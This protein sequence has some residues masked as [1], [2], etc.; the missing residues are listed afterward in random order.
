MTSCSD[1]AADPNGT[2]VYLALGAN[3]GDR[4]RTLRCAVERLCCFLD[5]PKCSSVY[6]TAPMYVLDQPLFLNLVMTGLTRKSAIELLRIAN[7]IEHDLGRD[8]R[9]ER[10][11][12]PRPLDIDMLLYGRNVCSDTTLTLPHPRIGER[13][14]VLVPLL[15]LDSE[16]RDPVTTTRYAD[17]PVDR[18]GIFKTDT[19]VP[20]VK[21]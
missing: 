8:R 18:S 10:R 5:D 13:A 7:E 4:S 11:N 16:L 1:T 19:V 2:V 17:I 9:S 6:E 21:A 12:G 20:V 3:L 14:F 15:E